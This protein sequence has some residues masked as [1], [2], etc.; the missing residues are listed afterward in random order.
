MCNVSIPTYQCIAVSTSGDPTGSYFRYAYQLS[1]NVFY[2]YPK[3]GVWPD[4]YY[5][6]ANRDPGCGGGPSA[7]AFDRARML[8]GDPGAG[9][10]EV[11]RNIW[12]INPVDLDGQTLPPP[13][14]PG[15]FVAF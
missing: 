5:M 8:V 1:T 4:G 12:G 3:F 14:A 7:I 9:L 6:S 10:Q 11:Q 15:V 2:D 13:A